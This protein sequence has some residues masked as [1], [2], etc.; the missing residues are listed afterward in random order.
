MDQPYPQHT[1]K[2][3]D[4]KESSIISIRHKKFSIDNPTNSELEV[5]NNN[6]YQIQ[7]AT[8]QDLDSHPSYLP[9]RLKA[10]ATTTLLQ[11]QNKR[12]QHRESVS[13]S[14]IDAL[15]L[16]LQ[17]MKLKSKELELMQNSIYK[18]DQ[19]QDIQE[20]EEKLDSPQKKRTKKFEF[21]MQNTNNNIDNSLEQ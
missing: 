11:D 14:K 7:E 16:R 17:Q 4:S 5:S 18:P 8:S 6:S 15:K 10:R 9:F 2:T 12:P 19:F 21:P 3:I 1:F 20:I 13:L